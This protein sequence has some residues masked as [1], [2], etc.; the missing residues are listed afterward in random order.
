MMKIVSKILLDADE[1]KMFQSI[2]EIIVLLSIQ[3][4]DVVSP[5]FSVSI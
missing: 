5:Y 3:Y 4:P 1:D 2:T